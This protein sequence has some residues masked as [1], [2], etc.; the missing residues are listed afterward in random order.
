MRENE[1]LPGIFA[2][3]L[4]LWAAEDKALVIADLHLGIEEMYNRQGI[5]LPRHN[6]ADIKKRLERKIFP[7]AKPAVIVINGDLK[8]EFGSISE[9]EW[10]EV[11]GMLRLLQRK[12]KK[13]VLV[14]GNH[15]KILGP[16]AKWEGIEIKDGGVLLP[17]SGVFV[18]HGELIPKSGLFR[19]AHTVVIGHEHPA[20]TIKEQYK[21]EQFKCFLVGRFKLKRL[22][23]QP[24]MSA[25]SLG[26][27]VLEEGT[28]SPFLKEGMEKFKVYAVADKVYSFGEL[29]ELE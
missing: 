25:V 8:H 2:L 29:R 26:T 15:D 11:T 19:Q 22:I 3:D 27:D 1:L 28:L 18:T 6:F 9:Q 14:R 13:I 16:I 20:V 7:K 21:H 23:V 4:G 12:C 10:Q 5:L 24:S 17:K